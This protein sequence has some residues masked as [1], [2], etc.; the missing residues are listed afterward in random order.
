MKQF[1]G[2]MLGALVGVIIASVISVFII[3]GVISSAFA[4]E[5]KVEVKEN[6][7]LHIKLDGPVVD[8]DP[9]SEF[10]K[11]TGLSDEKKMGLDVIVEGIRIAKDDDRIKGIYL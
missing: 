9:E 3:I 10:A 5:E 7:V 8:R 6:S 1:F 11:L 4:D 2:S